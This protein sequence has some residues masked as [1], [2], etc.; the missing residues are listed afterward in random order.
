MVHKIRRSARLLFT[1]LIIIEAG[2]VSAACGSGDATYSISTA[3]T[4]YTFEDKLAE[5]F[6]IAVSDGTV[7]VSDGQSG[8]IV[9]F[10]PGDT[11]A[12]VLGSF[13]TPSGLAADPSGGIFFADAGTNSVKRVLLSGSSEIVAGREGE[14]GFADGDVRS[15]LFNGPVGIAAFSDGR[16]AVADTYNDRIRVI[17]NGTVRTLA[18][19]KQG[20]AEG[21]GSS[22][23]F[24]TPLGIAI[25]QGDRLL[26]A[27]SGN[28]RLRVVEPDGRVW[29][30]AGD[31]G[32]EL[33]DG[34]PFQA[35]F[36]A[37]AAVA[38]DKNGAI[39]VSDGNA[40]RAI[41]LRTFPYVETIA[42]GPRGF[43]DGTPRQA[44]FNR[45][46]GIAAAEGQVFIADSE[47]G[48][49]RLIHGAKKGL[50]EAQSIHAR[51][52]RFTPEEFRTLQPGRWPY[53]PP[54]R[55]REI[56]GTLGEIRGEIT[57]QMSE[58]WF[59]NGLD[60]PGSYGE[61]ARSVREE[62]VLDP[63]AA[64][65]FGTLRE[66]LRLPMVGYVHLRL[67]RGVDERPFSDSRFLFAINEMTKK[68][69]NVRVPR[70]VKFQRGEAIGTLNA[71]NHVH[72]IAGRPGSEMNALDALEL[73]GVSDSIAPVI[74]D[75]MFYDELWQPVETK[76]GVERITLSGKT[77]IVVRAYDRM[78]GNAERRR[79]AP[80]KLG[81][82]L[83]NE[84]GPLDET[85]WTISFENMP[86]HELVRLA[87]APGSKSGATGET[88]FNF[89]V[90][91]RLNGENFAQGF[92]D[93]KD[94]EAGIYML[95]ISASDRFGNI[96]QKDIGIEVIK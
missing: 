64:Q 2:L 52:N 35:S 77:R 93:L 84:K 82:I 80:Y 27:D 26:V 53:D 13:D 81:Y 36:V 65:N 72:L 86:P 88:I 92:L 83:A 42:G 22:A 78:D 96:S 34:Y 68:P 44:R 8:K 21:S 33:R 71:M 18:G 14:R 66:L 38:V 79:L 7:Y 5:P 69:V 43:Q 63:H 56:A 6:G 25:W 47:N 37:P 67:G 30:L 16:I 28:R 46:S 1:I 48:R 17:E 15:A 3:S 41:G 89:V 85:V 58:A 24:D 73:P 20:F 10:A 50:V 62:K 31:G 49:V 45:P 87:Y 61:M 70:G 32:V 95:R 57:D 51:S 29:T 91:N 60:I 23:M 94:T 11:E 75:V 74:E 4:F 12:R 54:D 76:K 39:F 40:I 55:P 9:Y 59:H 90:T 19:G